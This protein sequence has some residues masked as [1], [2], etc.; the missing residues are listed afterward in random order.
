MEHLNKLC[1][2]VLILVALATARECYQ[3]RD[4]IAASR[5]AY[6]ARA[7]AYYAAHQPPTAAPNR[8]ETALLTLLGK[9]PEAKAEPVVVRDDYNRE[10]Y[11][12]EQAEEHNLPCNVMLAIMMQ[13]TGGN[14]YLTSSAGA[15]GLMQIMPF[16]AKVCGL[17]NQ[18]ELW[19][20]KKNI[21]CSAVILS[22]FYKQYNKNLY[23]AIAGYNG[24]NNC[25]ERCRKDGKAVVC[26]SPCK[27]THDYVRAVIGN[28]K[29]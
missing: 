16:N 22:R 10:R 15:I 21:R 2:A 12:C 4:S 13:E 8:I 18:A 5:A 20:E 11:I 24:G 29:S 26:I 19:D 9:M 3:H 28:M 1:L 7:D 25:Q 27:E 23:K 14:H 6:R 17:K